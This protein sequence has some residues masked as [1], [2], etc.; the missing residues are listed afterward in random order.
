MSFIRLY[1][2]PKAPDEILAAAVAATLLTKN[3]A[4][5]AAPFTKPPKPTKEQ[6]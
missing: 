5:T 2:L 3:L 4:G 6:L 1:K